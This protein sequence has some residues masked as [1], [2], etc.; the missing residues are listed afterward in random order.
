MYSPVND[1][2]A[3][4]PADARAGAS[5]AKNTANAMSAS[6]KKTG[7]LMYVRIGSAFRLIHGS[8][9]IA[10]ALISTVWRHVHHGFG[11]EFNTYMEPYTQAHTRARTHE[12][13]LP[14]P[15]QAA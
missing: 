1:T 4:V 10:G 14:N 2:V 5:A 12:I 11:A 7:R 3:G 6:K 8:G 15:H 13:P 9:G